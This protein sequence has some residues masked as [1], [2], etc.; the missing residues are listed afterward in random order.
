MYDL[1]SGRQLLQSSYFVGKKKALEIF[2]MLKRD[3]LCGGIVYFDGECVCYSVLLKFGY[4]SDIDVNDVSM[5]S[6]QVPNQRK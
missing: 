3:N 1:I 5:F 4:S 6:K 2:P